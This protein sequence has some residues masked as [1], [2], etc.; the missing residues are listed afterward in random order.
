M[1]YKTKPSEITARDRR[2]VQQF[3]KDSKAAGY[4][5]TLTTIVLQKAMKSPATARKI[6]QLQNKKPKIIGEKQG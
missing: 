1:A 3:I 5:P 4:D 2:N 6:S